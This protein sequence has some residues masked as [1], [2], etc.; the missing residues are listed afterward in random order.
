M[1]SLQIHRQRK[2]RVEIIGIIQLYSRDIRHRVHHVRKHWT[3]FV[4]ETLLRVRMAPG[5]ITW[6]F[7][8]EIL[9]PV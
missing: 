3:K 8:G 6:N 5:S 1:A 9:A 4:S 2:L 7:E